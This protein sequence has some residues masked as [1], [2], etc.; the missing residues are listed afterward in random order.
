MGVSE[1]ECSV[2][3]DQRV[4]SGTVCSFLILSLR[5]VCLALCYVACVVCVP[6][7]AGAKLL[8]ACVGRRLPVDDGIGPTA[9]PAEPAYWPLWATM[10]HYGPLYVQLCATMGHYGPLAEPTKLHAT[11]WNVDEDNQGPLEGVT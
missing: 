9:R 7:F 8:Q 2:Q 6:L 5:A 11:K 10:G 3:P 4:Q 1:S